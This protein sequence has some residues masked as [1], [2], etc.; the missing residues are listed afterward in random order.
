MGIAGSLMVIIIAWWLA[1]FAM[2]PIG[3]RSQLEEGNI[4]PGTEPAAPVS[5]NLGRKAIWAFVIA[6]IL[7]AG[8]YA[9]LEYRPIA[10]EDI[11]IPT[12]LKWD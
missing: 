9:L 12:G 3:V 11:P 4:V 2:L 1:F 8:L 6:I 7:W 5:P 10:L